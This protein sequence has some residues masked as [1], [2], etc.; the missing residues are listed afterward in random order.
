M[1]SP[2]PI[3]QSRMSQFGAAVLKLIPALKEA[4]IHAS[5]IDQLVRSANSVGANYA[6][7]RA[8]ESRADFVHKLQVALKEARE[9]MHHL[10]TLREMRLAPQ[11]TVTALVGVFDQFCAILYRSLMTAKRAGKIDVK[12]SAEHSG[13]DHTA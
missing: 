12:G 4:G 2:Y 8:A 7:A 1:T 6:E 3:I 5:I 11:R 10:E 9:A 13:P